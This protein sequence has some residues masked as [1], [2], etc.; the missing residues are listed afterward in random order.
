M[1]NLAGKVAIVTGAA[2][3][4][5][6]EFAQAL[7]AQ[8]AAV[9]VADIADPQPTVAA[10]RRAGGQALGMVADVTDSRAV[11]AMV[12][13]T[14]ADF[15]GVHI[16]VNNAAIGREGR[17][18]KVTDITSEYWHRLMAVNVGGTFECVKAVVP[19]MRAQG[20]GKIINLASGVFWSGPVNLAHYAASKGAIIGF[21]RSI[22][23]ELGGDGIRANCLAPGLTLSPGVQAD[24]VLSGA[25]AAAQ[26]AS[27][28]LPRDAYPADL[29]GPLL[30]LAGPD[31]DFVTGQV[32]LVDGGSVMH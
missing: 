16:L 1:A 18:N 30:Y 11:A 31:S 32:V 8:G 23:R 14:V 7:A 25:S 19:V 29:V 12:A 15:G 17:M 13:R 26:R 28:A 20:Y 22:A 3:G 10:I 5:G 27:R 21:T 6:A 9:M 2:Q 4:I 24:P